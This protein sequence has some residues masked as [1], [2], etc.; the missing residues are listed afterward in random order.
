MKARR[1]DGIVFRVRTTHAGFLVEVPDDGDTLDELARFCAD[2]SMKGHIIS[3][4]SRVFDTD[5][6]TPR[7]CV[8]S[9]KEY[10][11]EIRRLMEE[12]RK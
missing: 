3:S 2:L 6:A 12:A 5:T 1:I 8:L 9:S 10:K 4:V 11:N 7:V